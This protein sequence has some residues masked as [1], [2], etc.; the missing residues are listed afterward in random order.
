M[1]SLQL[2]PTPT[3]A[4]RIL[5]VPGTIW[6]MNRGSGPPWNSPQ[7]HLLHVPSEQI[8]EQCGE[9]QMFLL[10]DTQLRSLSKAGC[11]QTRSASLYYRDPTDSG[12]GQTHRKFMTN[13]RKMPMQWTNNEIYFLNRKLCKYLF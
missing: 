1:L 10:L 4:G 5:L 6:A 9:S 3:T 12:L 7:L 13:T 8:S 2:R 11:S